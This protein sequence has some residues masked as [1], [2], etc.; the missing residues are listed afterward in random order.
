M[1]YKYKTKGTCSREIFLDVENGVI[2]D[3]SFVGGCKGNLKGISVMVKGMRAEEVIA[4]L[5]GIRCGL[6]S[7]SCPDQLAQAL[8]QMI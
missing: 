1:K 3:V 5:E 8:K 6:K 7:T 4:K 2:R